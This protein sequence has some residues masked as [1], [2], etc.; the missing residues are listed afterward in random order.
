MKKRK[1]VTVFSVFALT[2]VILAIAAYVLT[3]TVLFPTLKESMGIPEDYIKP[4]VDAYD[5]LARNKDI[6][7]A[8]TTF[9]E[10]LTP[11]ITVFAAIGVF[12]I[13]AI[14]WLIVDLVR[15]RKI[16]IFF[17]IIYLLAVYTDLIYTLTVLPVKDFIVTNIEAHPEAIVLLL[18]PV[19]EAGVA[20]LGSIFAVILFIVDMA[21]GRVEKPETP[22]FIKEPTEEV[23]KPIFE[24]VKDENEVEEEEEVAVAPAPV[25]EEVEEEEAE[26]EEEKEEELPTKRPA[27]PAKKVKKEPAPKKAAPAKKAEVKKEEKKPAPK[28]AE[29]AKKAAPI[30]E[31]AKKEDARKT[32]TILLQNEE[33]S[34]YAKAFHVSRRAEL[35]KWQVKATGSDK[36]L[37]LFNTQKEAIEY[38]NQLAK[39][40]NVSV[41][42]HS[43]E[44]KIRKHQ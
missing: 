31:E 44:G 7:A 8:F 21:T 32:Q 41:R 3:F 15:G 5:I 33:G 1:G 2:F 42:V 28:K 24:E 18:V 11:N 40:Q 39:N 29:P 4:L 22:A 12:A 34:T 30:K 37:K 16:G 35:N 19:I 10:D 27:A 6:L 9:G 14:I 38:A 17:V 43:K 13:V 25:E 26:P 36:A 20:G 23:E